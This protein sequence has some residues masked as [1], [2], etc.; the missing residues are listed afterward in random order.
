MNK[1]KTGIN[2]L[3]DLA[4]IAVFFI[5]YEQTVIHHLDIF[6]ETETGGGWLPYSIEVDWIFFKWA[7][8]SILLALIL[9]RIKQ[10]QIKLIPLL[11]IAVLLPIT[12]YRVNH[13]I[14]INGSGV[15]FKEEQTIVLD[16][17]ER[18]KNFKKYGGDLDS[19]TL[20]Q[21]PILLTQQENDRFVTYLYVNETLDELYF[22]MKRTPDS[23]V[24]G[25]GLFV[26]NLD[27][28][29]L[30]EWEIENKKSNQLY[31]KI[32]MNAHGID[33]VALFDTCA[34]LTRED[35]SQGYFICEDFKWLLENAS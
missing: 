7:V 29:P 17:K 20:E 23:V 35:G 12:V 25:N 11:L 2:L 24:H 31:K 13:H 10:L 27:R 30:S 28:H 4:F 32:V 16:I 5:I 6:G 26:C 3:I 22:F 21:Y 14:F 19:Q 1:K 33:E 15:A 9:W 8:V 34:V 18:E